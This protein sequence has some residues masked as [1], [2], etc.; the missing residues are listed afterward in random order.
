MCDN[1]NSFVV[2][3]H[4]LSIAMLCVFDRQGILINAVF[5]EYGILCGVSASMCLFW[6]TCQTACHV[7]KVTHADARPRALKFS[8]R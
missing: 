5:I 3:Y 1:R 4:L 6:S 7:R 8:F 2:M